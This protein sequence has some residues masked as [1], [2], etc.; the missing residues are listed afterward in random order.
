MLILL[1][2][3]QHIMMMKNYLET[4]GYSLIDRQSSPFFGDIC[5][6]F[7]KGPIQFRLT[8][9]KSFESIDVRNAQQSYEWFDLVLVK[10]I[11][12]K[13]ALLNI[14]TREKDLFH[15]LRDH[16]VDIES[17]FRE[18]YANVEYALKEL[19]LARARQMFP[20]QDI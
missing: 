8:K 15:F 10:A 11:I 18:N 3:I 13:E 2:F 12:N 16:L 19:E 4:Y 20:N 7:G 17:M 14:S 5:E 1:G 6:V 9:S